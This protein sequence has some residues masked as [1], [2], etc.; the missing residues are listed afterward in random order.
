MVCNKWILAKQQQ[1]QQQ[2]KNKTTTKKYRIPKIESTELKKLNKPKYPSDDASV[3][4]ERDG[5]VKKAITR[6]GGVSER[7]WEGN[8]MESR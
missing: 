2:N 5:R 8:W 3:S 4:L 1:Q 6:G 7:S